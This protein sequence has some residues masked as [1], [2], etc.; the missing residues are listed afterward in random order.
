MKAEESTNILE[1]CYMKY[2]KSPLNNAIGF[3]SYCYAFFS[4]HLPSILL[5][6]PPQ[7]V[8]YIV[9]LLRGSD[10]TTLL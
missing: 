2:E 10:V 6:T 5:Q 1:S 7:Y 3:L 8:L 9:V 4:A